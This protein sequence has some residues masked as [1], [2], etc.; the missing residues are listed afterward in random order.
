MPPAGAQS[1]SSQPAQVGVRRGIQGV[2]CAAIAVLSAMDELSQS[3]GDN[4][5][6]GTLHN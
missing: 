2:C 5:L 4:G 1:R 6:I 3:D